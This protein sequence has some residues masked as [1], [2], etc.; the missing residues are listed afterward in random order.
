LSGLRPRIC[1]NSKFLR[2]RDPACTVALT[3][4]TL[5]HHLGASLIFGLQKV[6]KRVVAL[7]IICDRTIIVPQKP[8]MTETHPTL[9]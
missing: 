9:P 8:C 4:M 5:S 1:I 6:A 3:A 7:S 2:W